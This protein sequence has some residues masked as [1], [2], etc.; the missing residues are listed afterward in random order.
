MLEK[1]KVEILHELNSLT[2][3]KKAVIL[4]FYIDGL[5]WERISAQTNYSP[6][7]CRNIRDNAIK[8]LMKNFSEN[9]VI[10]NYHFPE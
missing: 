10:A 9:K 3:H 1:I 7:Q 5:Q 8:Q 6:R 4:G 2:F